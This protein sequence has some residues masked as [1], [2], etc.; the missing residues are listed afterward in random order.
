[1]RG[2]HSQR[3]VPVR[4]YYACRLIITAPGCWC[5]IR[6]DFRIT[7]TQL[8]QPIFPYLMNAEGIKLVALAFE[9]DIAMLSCCAG[10]DRLRI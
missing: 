8:R 10:S 5:E 7:C 4:G 2:I 1:M 3:A 9:K 6:Q